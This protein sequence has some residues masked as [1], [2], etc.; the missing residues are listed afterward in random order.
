[1][2]H[3]E[4]EFGSKVI[5]FLSVLYLMMALLGIG[6]SFGA[7][8]GTPQ[9]VSGGGGHSKGNLSEP[10]EYRRSPLPGGTRHAFGRSG[11]LRPKEHNGSAR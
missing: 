2:A 6:E 11:R 4:K 3:N 10:G 1:M 9:T 8:A 7:A 5:L